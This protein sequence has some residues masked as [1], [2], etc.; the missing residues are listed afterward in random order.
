MMAMTTMMTIPRKGGV[1]ERSRG[2]VSEISG[3]RVCHMCSV[4]YCSVH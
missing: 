3:E 4:V 1:N 2:C